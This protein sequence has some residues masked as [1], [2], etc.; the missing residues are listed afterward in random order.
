MAEYFREFWLIA[1]DGRTLYP[2]RQK[3]KDTGILGYR[4]LAKGS[5]RKSLGRQYLDPVEAIAAFLDG[6]SLR[7]GAPGHSANR[8]DVDGPKTASVDATPAFRA[9]HPHLRF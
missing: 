5:N 6:A 9:A 2:V 4:A 3:D 8:F 7:F 1:T